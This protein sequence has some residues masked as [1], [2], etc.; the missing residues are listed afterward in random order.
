MKATG[1][2]RR[3]DDLGRVVIPRETRRAL[4]IKEGD[5]LEIFIEDGGV[6]LKKYRPFQDLMEFSEKYAESLHKTSGHIC[7]ITDR[8]TIISVNGTSKRDFLEKPISEKL[9]NIID[10][11]HLFIT[12][13]EQIN[14]VNGQSLNFHSII[15]K[16]IM[17]EG[18]TC[19]S[20][21][22]AS[23]VNNIVFGEVE[24]KLVENAADFLGKQLED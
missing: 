16:P 4:R 19:G 7:F 24:I 15:I 18:E 20:V 17:S 12:N 23:T 21:I 1:I 10:E 13:T 5:P 2:V 22:L 14:I 3:I 8:D 11:R 6:I 9:E